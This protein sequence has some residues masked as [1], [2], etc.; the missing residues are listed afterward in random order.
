MPRPF[1]SGDVARK[2]SLLNGLRECCVATDA[3]WALTKLVELQVVGTRKVLIEKSGCLVALRHVGDR[4][5]MYSDFALLAVESVR[6]KAERS[7]DV[8]Q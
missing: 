6:T 8:I 1:S 4:D 2:S 5:A 3:F 7:R